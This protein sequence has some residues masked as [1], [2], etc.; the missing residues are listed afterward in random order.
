M[1]ITSIKSGDIDISFAQKCFDCIPE[2]ERKAANMLEYISGVERNGFEDKI[3]V[4]F[5][6]SILPNTLNYLDANKFSDAPILLEFQRR[7]WIQIAQLLLDWGISR[8]NERFS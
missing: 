6:T 5:G 4:G 1:K 7:H 3:F 2:N 8:N